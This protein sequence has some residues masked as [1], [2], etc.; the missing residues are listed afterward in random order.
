M[1]M[2]GI[3]YGACNDRNWVERFANEHEHSRNLSLGIAHSAKQ[4]ALFAAWCW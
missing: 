4:Y 1:K 2:K 3:T